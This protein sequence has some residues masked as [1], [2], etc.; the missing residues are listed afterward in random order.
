MVKRYGAVCSVEGTATGTYN[1]VGWQTVTIPL[2]QFITG[3]QFYQ[4]SW[5]PAGQPASNFTSYPTTGVGFLIANDTAVNCRREMS[6]I[7]VDNIRIVQ[8]Q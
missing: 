1:P 7:A 8:G 3:N 4:T 6:T 5:M 2:S